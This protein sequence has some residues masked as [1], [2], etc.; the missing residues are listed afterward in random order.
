M[1]N[2]DDL[3]KLLTAQTDAYM[4]ASLA[5]AASERMHIH[6]ALRCLQRE[7]QKAL[8]DPQ[9]RMMS[10][11]QLAIMNVLMLLPP[12]AAKAEWERDQS[13][14]NDTTT[15]GAPLRPGA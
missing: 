5:G 7:F 2:N 1:D 4:R 15:S 11:L 10:S 12:T 6:P 8:R 9:T 14:R 3:L 13:G